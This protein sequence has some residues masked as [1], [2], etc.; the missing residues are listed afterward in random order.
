MATTPI[1]GTSC[2]KEHYLNADYGVRSWLLTIDHKRIALL[3]LLS[4]TVVFALGGAYAVAIRLELLTPQGDLFTSETYNKMFTAHGVVMVFF[5]LIPAIPGDAG[6]LPDPAHDR[7]QGPGLPAD[8][9]AV[10]V[11]LRD[12]R[13]IT[14]GAL[15]AGGLDTGW[16]FYTPYS[17]AFCQQQR[18]D[19]R[20]RHLRRRLLLDPHR[21]QL[22]RHHPQACAP[23]A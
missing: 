11:P 16:T 15:F 9:P 6:E 5:F 23:R 17:T 21:L 3:Y 22:H 1:T 4:I 19:G 12:R 7:G 13:L 14:L 18:D 10:L 2:P 8:Q 20:G